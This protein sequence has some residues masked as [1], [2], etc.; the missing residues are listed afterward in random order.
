MKVEGQNGV[1]GALTLAQQMLQPACFPLHSSN[2][3]FG[4]WPHHDFDGNANYFYNY[5]SIPTGNCILK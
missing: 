1:N 5:F 2:L 3:P 4:L